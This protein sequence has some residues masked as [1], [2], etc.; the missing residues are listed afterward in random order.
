MIRTVLIS[1]NYRL[2]WLGCVTAALFALSPTVLWAQEQDKPADLTTL[3]QKYNAAVQDDRLDDAVRIAEEIN[4]LV[5]E[6]HTAVLLDIARLHARRGDKVKCFQS[7]KRLQGAGYWDVRSIMG[8]EA[9]AAYRQD[10]IFKELTRA[11]WANGYLFMLERDERR[12]FQKPEE[13]MQALALK[14]GERVADIGAGSGYFTVPVAKA[15][16]PTGRVLAVDIRQEMLDYL[17]FR[18]RAEGLANVQLKKVEPDDPLLPRGEVDTILMVDVLH[19]IKERT[20]YARKLRD[21]LTPGGRL[22]VIDYRPRPFA[23]RPWGPPPEQQ[24]SKESVDQDM[25]GAGFKP[26]EVY[27]FLPEQYFVVYQISE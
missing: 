18:L 16:G 15:V 10:T 5:Q 13:V 25:A 3:R 20:A 9:F 22:V 12:D 4:W 26:V 8:D 27:E 23:E 19:Y 2:L 14:P 17:D 7:L 6:P 11:I 24:M 1:R 21:A